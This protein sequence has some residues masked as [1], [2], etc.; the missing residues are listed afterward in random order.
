MELSPATRGAQLAT[1]AVSHKSQQ[2]LA[3]C[4]KCRQSLLTGSVQYETPNVFKT[5]HIHCRLR[6]AWLGRN[7][8]SRPWY[9]YRLGIQSYPRRHYFRHL[10]PDTKVRRG[11]K[12]P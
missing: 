10:E 6:E 9:H 2:S 7:I 5:A 4:D 8:G 11:R 12:V 1:I 3:G